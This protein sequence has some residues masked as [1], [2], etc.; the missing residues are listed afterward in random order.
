MKDLSTQIADDVATIN[1]KDDL[2]DYA[3]A[4]LRMLG[5]TEISNAIK[6]RKIK[7]TK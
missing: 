5:E 2:I 6:A 3:S 1:S 4:V 7:L